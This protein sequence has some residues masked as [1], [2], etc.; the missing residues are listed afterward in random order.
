M[1]FELTHKNDCTDNEVQNISLVMSFEHLMLTSCSKRLD[2][3]DL[4]G[5]IHAFA[6]CNGDLPL[7]VTG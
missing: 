7:N 1:L 2:I 5:I 4:I 3:T 6:L